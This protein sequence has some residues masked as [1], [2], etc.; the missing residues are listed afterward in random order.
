MVIFLNNDFF[1]NFLYYFLIFNFSQEF[2]FFFR[3]RNAPNSFKNK[4]MHM[5]QKRKRWGKYTISTYKNSK[6]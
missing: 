5:C 2:F 4:K 1:D 3:E 6:I